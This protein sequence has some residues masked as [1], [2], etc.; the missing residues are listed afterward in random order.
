MSRASSIAISIGAYL[1][2]LTVVFLTFRFTEGYSLLVRI[3]V[4]DLIGTVVIFL[5]SLMMNNSSMYDPYWSVKPFV[6]AAYLFYL[7]PAG[8]ATPVEWA[9]LL[10]V[11]LYA[12][13]LTANF[14]R[15]WSGMDHEDWRYRDFRK[16][17]PGYYWIISFFGIHFFPTVMVYLGC[18]PMLVIFGQP[19]AVPWMAYA[20]IA[21]MLGAVLLAYV[22]DEQL[23]RFRANPANAGKT[24]RTGLWSRSRHPNYLGEILT[25]WGLFMVALASGQQYWWTGLGA[26]AITLMFVF[27]SIPL[28]ERYSLKR[29]IDYR[30]YRQQV[31]FLLPLKF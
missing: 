1:V 9:V 8:E 18:I 28:I 5:F 13:R 23:R 27:I 29:R 20:G 14:Y 17:F 19:V 15:G 11:F 24:I 6:I 21:V 2:A 12:L 4:A 25:W 30:E 10:A 16:Q 22:A 26:L 7:L 31:P 3:A